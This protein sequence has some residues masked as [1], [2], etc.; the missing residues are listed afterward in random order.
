MHP[1]EEERHG[2]LRPELEELGG[3]L[4]GEPPM[5]G[6]CLGSQ[7]LAR[8]AGAE[9]RGSAEPRWGGCLSS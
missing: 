8:A 1:D 4:E 9:V 2:W 3:L 7:L 5:L 6:V